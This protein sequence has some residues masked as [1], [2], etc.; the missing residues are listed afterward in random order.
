MRVPLGYLFASHARTARVSPLVPDP[1]HL[2]PVAVRFRRVA[3]LSRHRVRPRVAHHPGSYA[4]CRLVRPGTGQVG[5][6][7]WHRPS[8]RRAYWVLAQVL[9]PV[10]SQ[11]PPPLVAHLARQVCT[12]AVRSLLCRLA[13]PAIPRYSLCSAIDVITGGCYVL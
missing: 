6:Y 4:L 13:C 7:L 11:V 5:R 1:A 3:T 10:A 9:H 12:P 8:H 2:S